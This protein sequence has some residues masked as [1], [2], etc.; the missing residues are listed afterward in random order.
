[1]HSIFFL[2]LLVSLVWPEYKMNP[3]PRCIFQRKWLSM[4]LYIRNKDKDESLAEIDH[5]NITH[6][7]M[8]DRTQ[9]A[10]CKLQVASVH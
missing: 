1:M 3:N 10:S 5:T 2:I 4:I 7:L 6:L 8:W 9:L